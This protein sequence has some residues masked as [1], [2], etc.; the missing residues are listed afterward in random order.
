MLNSLEKGLRISEDE[1]AAMNLKSASLLELEALQER[2]ITLEGE[3]TAQIVEKTKI[4]M[5]QRGWLMLEE[6]IRIKALESNLEGMAI[7]SAAL[8]K[9]IALRNEKVTVAKKAEAVMVEETK[10]EIERT[11]VLEESIISVKE[12]ALHASI[13]EAQF[14]KNAAAF[15]EFEASA[16]SMET[17]AYIGETIKE[18]EEL[19]AKE[20]ELLE[21]QKASAA[22][23]KEAFA[24][25]SKERQSSHMETMFDLMDSD[26]QETERVK[27]MYDERA[28]VFKQHAGDTER[29][30]KG[31]A[32]AIVKIEEAKAKALADIELQ[33]K[34]AS[35]E[36]MTSMASSVASEGQA[37]FEFS[38]A[39]NIGQAIMNTYT[40]AT[41]AFAQGGIFGIVTGSIMVA[42]GMAQ[43]AKIKA[44]TFSPP[45]RE[46]GGPV[47][48]GRPYL[49]GERGPELFTPQT[50][51][52]I[53]PNSSGATT[54]NISINAVDTEGF[55]ELL[56]ARRAVIVSVI[57]QALHRQG[58]RGLV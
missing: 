28:E 17:P 49:V 54:V 41:K 44:T 40:A 51:G 16:S 39:L 12:Q 29:T 47:S 57:N 10:V 32:M 1:I 50:A 33:R 5:K 19:E 55:D 25:M 58:K 56:F 38:K 36:T 27:A 8:K 42:L 6:K 4:G 31:S 21:V 26:E 35:L 18:L 37:F 14:K 13:L 52:E 9:E 43:V 22:E 7:T 15:D 23:L 45:K 11:K 24:S 34:L 3:H 2:M 53:Q 30:A 46:F 20:Y 48:T